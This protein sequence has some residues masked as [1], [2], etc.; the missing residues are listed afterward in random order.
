[1]SSGLVPTTTAIS[2]PYWDAA[3]RHELVLQ[4]CGPCQRHVFH[5][6]ATCPYCG[7]DQLAWKPVSGRGEVH[8]YTVARRATHPAFAD[9]VPYII[10]IVELAEGPRLITN[11]VGC[12]PEAVRIAMPV[13]VDYRDIAGTDFTLPVFRPATSP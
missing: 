5:P 6:R 13:V 7:S 2:A 12:E 4:R 10:A 3:R 9:D 1:M 8:T 11:I